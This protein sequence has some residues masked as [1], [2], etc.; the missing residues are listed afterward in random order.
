MI[1]EETTTEAPAES[2]EQAVEAAE[3]EGLSTREAIQEAIK[4]HSEPAKEAPPAEV[5]TAKQVAQAV[6]DDLEPPAE[7][8]AAGKNAWKSKDVRGIQQ[9]FK[10]IH[11][12]RTT[13]IT[14][15]QRAEREA[16]AV[17]KP[18]KELADRVRN[19]LSVRGE[20]NLP[21][22]VKIAQALQLVDEMRKRDG[23]SVRAELLKMGIDLDKKG[24]RADSAD[25]NSELT[26]L[27]ETVLELKKDKDAQEFNR[28]IQTF[29]S[30]FQTLT[31]QKTRSG[32][33]LFPD[34]LDT[35]DE[36][37]ALAHEIGSLTRD[38]RFQAGVL[39]RFP[40]ADFTTVVR[41]AYKYAGGKVSSDTVTVSSA[42]NQQQIER[43]RRAAAA[44]PGRT[45]PRVNESS[46]K[47]KLSNRAALEKA[48]EMHKEQ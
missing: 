47:G 29:D 10:R 23:D 20:D 16:L 22:E 27:R 13:E 37:K 24:A 43:S 19:Y 1:D 41:E 44:N 12:S 35:S 3:S 5:P 32:E 8:S 36:G 18:A 38:D 25:N 26:S 6:D 7:F 33:P 17:A 2:V 30:A 21:D 46:L 39:R 42:S 45:A 11:D 40:D 48:W 31:S 14:R 4:I 28:T 15:A 34:L 9:E